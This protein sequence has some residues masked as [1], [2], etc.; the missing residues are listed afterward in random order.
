MFRDKTTERSIPMRGSGCTVELRK[1]KRPTPAALSL[2]DLDT[3]SHIPLD[4]SSLSS[5][6]SLDDT[7]TSSAFAQVTTNH[8]GQTPWDDRDVIDLLRVCAARAKAGAWSSEP[9]TTR[10]AFCRAAVGWLAPR[11]ADTP[12]SPNAL[13]CRVSAENH[14]E[15]VASVLVRVTEHRLSNDDIGLLRETGLVATVCHVI[16]DVTRDPAL[17]TL[18]CV[19]LG[20]LLALDALTPPLHNVWSRLVGV[21]RSC[22]CWNTNNAGG[23]H[24]VN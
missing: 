17:R 2:N 20:N 19:M 16:A 7:R 3:R 18:C 22:Q 5:S 11:D 15:S 8:C 1:R 12:P 13:W 23:D 24:A 6:S 9:L 21:T 10:E 4:E 14:A